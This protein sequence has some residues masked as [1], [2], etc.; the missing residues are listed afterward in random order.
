MTTFTPEQLQ[1]FTTKVVK[2]FDGEFSSDF[3]ASHR[4][5]CFYRIANFTTP[6]GTK[7]NDILN[8]DEIGAVINELDNLQYSR[9][10]QAKAKRLGLDF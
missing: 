6:K 4:K 2:V 8:D 3:I 1:E 10:L 7:V 5:T 9:R